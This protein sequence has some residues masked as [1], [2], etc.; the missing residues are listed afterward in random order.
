MAGI[1][2]MHHPSLGPVEGCAACHATPADLFGNAEWAAMQARAEE[3]G[4]FTCDCGFEY[5]KT[6]DSCPLCH[7][8][9]EIIIADVYR[10]RN[11]E[12]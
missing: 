11:E 10:K 1:C 3:A 6:V 7:K 8:K 12:T 5:Y 9:R 2:S 4:L